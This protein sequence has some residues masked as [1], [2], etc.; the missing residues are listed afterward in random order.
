MRIQILA[1][2]ELPAEGIIWDVGA[3]CGSIGLEALRIRPNLKLI[4]IDKR[5][6]SK[7]LIEENARRLGVNPFFVY[8]EDIN[9][10][11]SA[12]HS[13]HLKNATRIII[14]GC[15][16]KTK[17]RLINELSGNMCIG[18]IFIIP[19]IDIDSISELRKMLEFNNY[20]TNLNLI[21]TYKNLSISQGIRLDPNNPVF[22]LKGKKLI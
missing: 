4:S 10:L 19:I 7:K 12:E 17:V 18:S 11:L 22:L 2:L 1:D 14:G 3:G 5:I 21:Q 20:K 9:Q 8:E 6:G 16:K 13:D 15:D